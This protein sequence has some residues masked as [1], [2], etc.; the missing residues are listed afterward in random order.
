MRARGQRTAIPRTDGRQDP[1]EAKQ[2]RDYENAHRVIEDVG[3]RDSAC[4]EPGQ[5][6][7]G[8]P[9]G[10]D[11]RLLPPVLAGVLYRRQ[12][13]QLPLLHRGSLRAQLTRHRHLLHAA[14]TVAPRGDALSATDEGAAHVLRHADANT[15]SGLGLASAA[16]LPHLE[17][18]RATTAAETSS[19]AA[20]AR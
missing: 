13:C 16:T 1:A 14:A 8:A 5:L 12:R 6:L 19:A 9:A 15:R 4:V 20:T 18:A 17:A 3:I 11:E 2:T 10:H 7:P